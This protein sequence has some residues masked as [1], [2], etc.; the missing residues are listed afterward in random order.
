MDFKLHPV[1]YSSSV[2]KRPPGNLP[3]AYVPIP[4]STPPHP[5]Y[6]LNALI[7]RQT[8]F[9]QLIT[10]LLQVGLILASVF[11]GLFS[12]HFGRR[13]GFFVASLLAY[14]GVTIQILVTSQGPIYLGRLIMGTPSLSLL[15]VGVTKRRY[16]EWLIY[17]LS[18]SLYN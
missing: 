16:L 4:C 11:L 3:S 14:I 5:M 12:H 9:Q 2:P 1:S 8:T 10:S 18:G 15:S 17:E 6:T 7:I 13:Q